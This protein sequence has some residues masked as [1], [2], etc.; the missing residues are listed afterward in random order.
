MSGVG[1]RCISQADICHWQLENVWENVDI[2]DI[3][4][5]E[6]FEWGPLSFNDIR[7]LMEEYTSVL[8]RLIKDW[9]RPDGN[10]LSMQFLWSGNFSASDRVLQLLQDVNNRNSIQI[11]CQKFTFHARLRAQYI[12]RYETNR[13]AGG[14]AAAGSCV[15]VIISQ[16]S[17]PL[18][19]VMVMDREMVMVMA[20]MVWYVQFV[21]KLSSLDKMQS[22]CH[23]II[24]FTVVASQNGFVAN[25]HAHYADMIGFGNRA[26]FT[27]V[28]L[29]L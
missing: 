11:L 18:E 13:V 6:N 9:S 10:N 3:R 14:Y 17:Y 25:P 23:V 16:S 8:W 24:F 12:A 21:M 1:L 4:V 28:S 19:V 27:S 20:A 22:N 29:P 7:I 5:A 26:L 2:N 15:T